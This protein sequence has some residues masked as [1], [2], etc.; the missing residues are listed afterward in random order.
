MNYDIGYIENFIE[1]SSALY[2]YY[3]ER[4][5]DSAS[6]NDLM[7]ASHWYADAFIGLFSQTQQR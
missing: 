6:V 4:V 3:I 5:L 1:E 2:E 7:S